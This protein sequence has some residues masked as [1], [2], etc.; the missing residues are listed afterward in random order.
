[1]STTITDGTTTITPTEV[2]GFAGARPVGN[3]IIPIPGSVAPAI[4]LAPAHSR[5]GT[6]TLFFSTDTASATA[7]TMLKAGALFTL[8]STTQP[9]INMTFVLAGNLARSLDQD[10]WGWALEVPYQE[11]T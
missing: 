3:L 2:L 8:A 6:L 4:S 9:S 10:S 11:T 1:M 7:E 5:A